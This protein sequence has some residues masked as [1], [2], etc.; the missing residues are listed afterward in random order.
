M[1]YNPGWHQALELEAMIDVSKMCALA[2]LG[3][4]KAEEDTQEKTTPCQIM[5]NG[6]ALNSVIS[7][8][9]Q[10]EMQIEHKSY[11][12]IPED[13]IALLDADD[14]EGGH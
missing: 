13:L 9:E 6:E 14:L 3:R 11:P 7:M 10:G 2:A 12:P 8:N 1:I 5:I 4:E